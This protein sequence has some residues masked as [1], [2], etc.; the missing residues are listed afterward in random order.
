MKFH[1][2]AALFPPMSEAEYETLKASIEVQG[3]LEPITLMNDQIIDGR[4][5]FEACMDLGI[6]PHYWEYKGDD[7][8]GYVIALNMDRR[9]L[10]TSQRAAIAAEIANLG[11]GQKK[12]D[13]EID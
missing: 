5:R 13:V 1:K 4:H 12:A 7:P 9:H 2:L 11:H 10:T 3:Q 6:E 8:L